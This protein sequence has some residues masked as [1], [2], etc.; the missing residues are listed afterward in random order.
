[1]LAATSQVTRSVLRRLLPHPWPR[2]VSPKTSSHVQLQIDFIL[3]ERWGSD[4]FILSS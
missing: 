1:M 3:V 4:G 2:T